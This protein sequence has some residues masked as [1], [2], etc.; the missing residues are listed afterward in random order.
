[1][2][3]LILTTHSLITMPAS[4][5]ALLLTLA[6]KTSG[7]SFFLGLII[8]HR[9]LNITTAINLF[10]V[11]IAMTVYSMQTPTPLGP[12]AKKDE[13]GETAFLLILFIILSSILA[14]IIVLKAVRKVLHDFR[15]VTR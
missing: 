4:L 13:M 14:L 3:L 12:M 10:I 11:K 15:E 8:M 5:S 7:L 9:L 2:V 1:I 6:G